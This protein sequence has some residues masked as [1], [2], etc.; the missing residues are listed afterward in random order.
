MF[1]WNILVLA[2]IC[3]LFPKFKSRLPLEIKN[4]DFPFLDS[5]LKSRKLE[6]YSWFLTAEILEL[7]KILDSCLNQDLKVL[8]SWFL[9][10]PLKIHLALLQG[11]IKY[12]RLAEFLPGKPD[13]HRKFGLFWPIL[14]NN[15]KENSVRLT[16]SINFSQEILICCFALPGSRKNYSAL[17]LR[18]T[19]QTLR[20]IRSLTTWYLE[21]Y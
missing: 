1:F 5:C 18:L 3:C 21:L 11:A 12:G 7:L 9:S 2:W 4:F 8:D 16:E 17:R 10:R 13:F 15:L 14:A 19:Y 20:K 6:K